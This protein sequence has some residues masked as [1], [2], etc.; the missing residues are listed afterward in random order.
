M[1]VGEDNAIERRIYNLHFP[2]EEGMSYHAGPHEEA[3]CLVRKQNQEEG[4][5]LSQ[6]FYCGFQR[7]GEAGQHKQL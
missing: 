5:S 7:K 4:E 3:S 1:T 6:S 2:R